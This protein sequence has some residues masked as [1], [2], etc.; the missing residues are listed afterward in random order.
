MPGRLI[1]ELVR[2]RMATLSPA[3]RRLGRALLAAYPVAGLESLGRFAE[4]AAVSPATVSRFIAKLGLRGYPEF[5]EALR[6][7]LAARL[8]SPVERLAAAS[9]DADDD[10]PLRRSFAAAEHSLRDTLSM[11]TE[12][13]F[14][15]VV[16]LL[17]DEHRRVIALGGRLSAP[18]A[19][20]LG[21]QLRQLR[22][23]VEVMAP[24]RATPADQ[25][26]DLGRRDVLVVFDYRR[27][28][29]D[30]IESAREAAAKGAAVV[31]VTDPWLSPAAATARHV[32]V[33]S[34]T[35]GAPF[36]SLVAG[37]AL[38]EALV[39]AVVGRL[40]EIARRRMR[41]LD[42]LRDRMESE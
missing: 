22:A 12:H 16:E 37:M 17:A 40:G 13:D 30:S 10:S 2:Q 27:Y 15:A 1:G 36:D 3:E 41:R 31:L 23:G 4:R 18:L 19:R 8:S 11:T 35:T 29:R 6:D 34:V 9:T 21:G 32:L 20:Y 39:A 14:D 25:L 7:E 42:E 24:D 5:Q 26:A 28:Q 33:T 38:V